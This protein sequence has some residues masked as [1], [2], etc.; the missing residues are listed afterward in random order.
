[1]NMHT[2]SEFKALNTKTL[3]LLNKIKLSKGALSVDNLKALIDDYRRMG[4]AEFYGE[5][6][7]LLQPKQTKEKRIKDASLAKLE[8][9]NNYAALTAKLFV[10]LTIEK[11]AEQGIKLPKLAAKDKTLPKLLAHFRTHSSEAELFRVGQMVAD[12]YTRTH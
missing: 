2:I 12:K 8:D 4:E 3:D 9:I 10:E 5:L 1:M 6:A 11:A 7:A